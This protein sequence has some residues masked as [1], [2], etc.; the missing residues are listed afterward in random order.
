M[1]VAVVAG[2]EI[3]KFFSMTAIDQSIWV[4]TTRKEALASL[5][6]TPGAD[7]G[8]P[9]LPPDLLARNTQE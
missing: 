1:T 7:N 4:F 6:A 3:R 2:S 8:E 5:R 9:P